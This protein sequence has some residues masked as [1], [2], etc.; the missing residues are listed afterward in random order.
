MTDTQ[1]RRRGP[2]PTLTDS[3]NL[4]LRLTGDQL[5]WIEA[6]ATRRR[7]SKGELVRRLITRAMPKET[8]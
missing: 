5:A 2:A 8:R 1:P 6:T 3:Q 7:I 4:T